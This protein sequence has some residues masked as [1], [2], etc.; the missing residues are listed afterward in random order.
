MTRMPWRR[1]SLPL[2]A[3]MGPVCVSATRFTYDS[4]LHMPGVF[5]NGLRL[6]RLWPQLDGVLGVA[7]SGDWAK[8]LTYTISVWRDEAALMAFVRH[9]LHLKMMRDYRPRLASSS[10]ANW[11]V[12]R[13]TLPEPWRR[14]Q[15]TLTEMPR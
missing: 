3:F 7:L 13:L 14:A 1:G 5:F 11:N 10:T 2:N 6:W 15:A 4:A 12:E 9:P 8:R